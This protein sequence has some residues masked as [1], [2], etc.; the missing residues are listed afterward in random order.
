MQSIFGEVAPHW[1]VWTP[2][3]SKN[4]KPW[5]GMPRNGK[6]WQAMAR[7][8]PQPDCAN[9]GLVLKA[10]T[11]A[12]ARWRQETGDVSPMVS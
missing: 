2:A 8:M 9:F 10:V 4:G 3:P 12:R 11:T 6:R 1:S 5:Q 7:Q